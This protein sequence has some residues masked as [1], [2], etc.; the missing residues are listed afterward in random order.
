M[1]EDLLRR[2]VELQER[3]VELLEIVRGDVV[4]ASP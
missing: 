4:E 3:S 2:I 1:S